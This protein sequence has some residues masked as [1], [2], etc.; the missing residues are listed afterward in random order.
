MTD[1]TSR[2]VYS[3]TDLNTLK[4]FRRC[5]ILEAFGSFDERVLDEAAFALHA[6]ELLAPESVPGLADAQKDKDADAVL[7]AVYQ[8]CKGDA[9]PPEKTSI[10][11]EGLEL[12]EGVLTH[13]FKFYD[14]THQLPDDIDWDFNP[15]TA[16]WGH[17]L[18]RFSYLSLLNRAY[19]A[20]GDTRFSR[21][22][23]ELILDWIAKCDIGQ[24]FVGTPYV[25]GSYLNNAIQCG[26]WTR[27][28]QQLLPAGQVRPEE[29]LRI[30]KA[31]HE[32]MCYLEIVTNG[33]SG[34]W[35]TIG[36]HSMLAALAAFPIFRETDRLATYCI[37]SLADQ[38]D[39]QILPDGAQD[40]LTPH[41]HRVVVSNILNAHR[42]VELLGRTL[43]PRTIDTLREMIHYFQQTIVPDGSA[44]VAFN[45]S[46]PESVG[47]PKRLLS[48]FGL[49]DYLSPDEN[50]G[51]E[52]FPYAGVALLRQKQTEGD[53]YLAF[54][55]GPYGRG[56]QHEDK[57][58]FWCFAYGRNFLVD[59][60]R[61]LYDHSEVSY[62]GYLKSTRAHSTILIDGQGQNSRA[63]PRTWIAR[64]PVPMDW[65]VGETEIRASAYY[66]LGYGPQNA[67]KVVHRREIVFVDERF[68]IVFDR[69]EGD[70]EHRVESRF[71][72]GPCELRVDS[73]R[74][75]TMHDD[76][77]LQLWA[78]PSVPF[79][80]IHIE[81]GQ[82]NPKGGWYSP[83]YG[84]I[85]P[86]P[87]M[88]LSLETSLPF[89]MATL[90]FPYRGSVSV[91]ISF[92]YEN[93]VATVISEEIGTLHI[94]TTLV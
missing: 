49:E 71:Q 54:D 93:A 10:S 42:S 27:C 77:N 80:D 26:T 24:C 46:D 94:E 13:R 36:C 12:A 30:L 57:L 20:T 2:P 7:N 92:S 63:Y 38:I 67:I 35:P 78:C 21:K 59:P 9:T 89:T 41:Y 16:H 62:Y 84:R 47:D 15:G 14:E 50:L 37:R 25:F 69:V 88:S 51:P 32:L 11:P 81:A 5:Q 39:D 52:L 48:G 85:Q 22:A 79:I 72:F 17:D 91:P 44:R 28:L 90:L 34:N 86:A 23:V 56:H 83:S 8:A 31:V 40:E 75:T 76:A 3:R 4:T 18:N 6:A 53:L 33:H 74:V 64:E 29:L 43:E 73:S 82:E 87:A 65:H 70:G 19:F 1:S 45:D 61:H 66:D 58:G 68:W 60:G 55:G